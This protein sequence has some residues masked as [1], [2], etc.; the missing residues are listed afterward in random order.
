MDITKKDEKVLRECKRV[1]DKFTKLGRV[2]ITIE[3]MH[4]LW[5][6]WNSMYGKNEKLSNCPS[7]KDRKLNDLRRSYELFD[8]KGAFN[9]VKITKSK[10]KPKSERKKKA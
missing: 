7:C 3:E 6:A 10:S 8:L 4:E 2:P 5:D 9:T 1:V